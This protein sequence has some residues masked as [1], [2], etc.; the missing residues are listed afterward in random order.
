MMHNLL[1]S[2]ILNAIG[3]SIAFIGVILSIVTVGISFLIHKIAKRKGN[4]YLKMAGLITAWAVFVALNAQSS[5]SSTYA[6]VFLIYSTAHIVSIFIAV[7]TIIVFL[8][9]LKELMKTF[10]KKFLIIAGVFAVLGLLMRII[11]PFFGVPSLSLLQ[12]I[13]IILPPLLGF[14][15]I[16]K[17]HIGR[18][19]D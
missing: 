14:F 3:L 8:F 11:F 1:S 15:M 7:I 19:N 6:P 10:D 13:V 18:G 9:I 2:E 17:S 5:S 16:I 4:E 12:R